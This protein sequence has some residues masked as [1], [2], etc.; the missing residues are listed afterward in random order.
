MPRKT[1]V[2][3]SAADFDFP[4]ACATA[5][6]AARTVT[7]LYDRHLRPSGLES[8]QFA[9][10]FVL[11]SQGPCSQAA[12]GHVFALDKTTLSRN[13]KFLK[14]RGW[15]EATTADDGRER[16]FILSAAGRKRLAEAR[17]AWQRAQEHLQSA[18][19]VKQWDAMWK[20][21]RIVTE[22][23]QRV[24]RDRERLKSKR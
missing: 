23:A 1:D 11:A 14:N 18:M 20:N 10:L 4:C 7:Q 21:F 6:R 17:P 12:V 9:L 2:R 19:G 5:R 8:T 3:P 22:A 24:S 16:R 15:I 13:L